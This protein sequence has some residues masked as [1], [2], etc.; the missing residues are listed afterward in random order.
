M[1]TMP[2]FVR[3]CY[4]IHLERSTELLFFGYASMCH[5]R[6]RVAMRNGSQRNKSP[7]GRTVKTKS[8]AIMEIFIVNIFFSMVTRIT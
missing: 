6:Y 7:F 1:R 2:N 5:I 4:E 8:G 3:Q